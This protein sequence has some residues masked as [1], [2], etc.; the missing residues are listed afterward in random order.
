MAALS[1]WLAVRLWL[2]GLRDVVSFEACSV[3]LSSLTN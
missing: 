2:R 1:R 3:D